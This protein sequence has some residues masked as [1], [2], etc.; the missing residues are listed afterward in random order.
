VPDDSD[1]PKQTIPAKDGDLEV[2]VPTRDEFVHLVDKVAHVQ[3]GSKEAKLDW[4]RKA[5]LMEL[6]MP[7]VR[8]A[9]IRE[10]READASWDEINEALDAARYR[11][12]SPSAS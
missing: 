1:R 11:P 5:N 2:E 4:I 7:E 12:D 8:D 10:A 6:G 3:P 9:L